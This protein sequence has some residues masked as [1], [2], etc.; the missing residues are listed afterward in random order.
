MKLHVSSKVVSL[1]LV[2]TLLLSVAPVVSATEVQPLTYTPLSNL[3]FALYPRYLPSSD[4]SSAS[5]TSLMTSGN[6]CWTSFP[7]GT[8][9]SNPVIRL[10]AYP[11]TSEE[12]LLASVYAFDLSRL[13]N[14]AITF[15]IKDTAS[16]DFVKRQ[17][18][19]AYADSQSLYETPIVVTGTSEWTKYSYDL[20]TCDL[21]QKFVPILLGMPF[22]ENRNIVSQPMIS[23]FMLES[24]AISPV[25]FEVSDNVYVKLA[26]ASPGVTI[27]YTTDGSLPTLSSDKYTE[28]LCL[29]N[30][31]TTTICAMA[32]DAN[33]QASALTSK[34]LEA[35]GDFYPTAD[36]AGG[37]VALGAEVTL[38]PPAGDKTPF[39]V[40]YTTNGTEPNLQSQVYSTPIPITGD[41]KIRAAASKGEFV[42]PSV[43]FQ[44]SLGGTPDGYEGVGGNDT[45]ISATDQTFPLELTDATLHAGSDVDYY[46]TTLDAE[47]TVH[48]TLGQ[49]QTG[50]IYA[51]ALLDSDGT[52]V[53][54]SCSLNVDQSITAKLPAGKYY[55]KVSSKDGAAFS[56]KSYTLKACAQATDSLNLS[57]MDLLTFSLAENSFY[58][59]CDFGINS[60]GNL[61]LATNYFTSWK[62]P[63]A[64]ADAP[65][66]ERFDSN[67]PLPKYDYHEPAQPCKYTASQSMYLPTA[68]DPQFRDRLKAAV[69]CYGA[70]DVS[71]YS[72]EAAT[73]GSSLQYCYDPV[74]ND[75]GNHSVTMIGWDDNVPRGN[76]SYTDENGAVQHP[77]YNGAY[78]VRNSWGADSASSGYFYISY[79]DASF[80]AVNNPAIYILDQ[81]PTDYNRQYTHNETG[82]S[83]SISSHILYT[84]NRFTCRSNES[85]K[86]V[87]LSI[88]SADTFYEISVSRKAKGGNTFS[89]PELKAV[90]KLSNAGYYTILLGS[91]FDLTKGDSFEVI[92]RLEGTPGTPASMLV[93]S[94]QSVASEDRSFP[95]ACA[96]A[97]FHKGESFILDPQ[98]NGDWID[99]VGSSASPFN[100]SI[101]AYTKDEGLGDSYDVAY[102]KNPSDVPATTV[103]QGAITPDSDYSIT[104]HGV[105]KTPSELPAG[106]GLSPVAIQASGAPS[107]SANTLPTQF[108]L[109]EIGVQSYVK[110][111]GILDSCWAFSATA[112]AELTYMRRNGGYE[113]PRTI[114]TEK[115][116]DAFS[117]TA[118]N[119]IY[120]AAAT[121]TRNDGGKLETGYDV[122]TWQFSGDLRSIDI[123]NTQS[124]SGKST[125]LFSARQPGTITLTAT[126]DGDL[127]RSASITVQLS[128]GAHNGPG[129]GGGGGSSVTPLSV[130]VANSVGG[131]GVATPSQVLPG[132]IVDVVLTP[133]LGYRVAGITIQDQSGNAVAFTKTTVNSFRFTM[134]KSKVTVTPL[135]E[136]EP[137]N[138]MGAFLDVHEG[139]W[140]Y[141]FVRYVCENELMN[142]TSATQFSPN[143]PMTRAMLS[144]ILWR[145][146]GE[147]EAEY[148]LRFS[149]YDGD[150]WYAQG[151]RW[152][153]SQDLLQG[154]ENGLLGPNDVI[155]REQLA[156]VLYRYA[157]FKGYNTT[158]PEET[159]I[160]NYDDFMHIS[161]WAYSAMNW[162][163][164][165]GLL[166]GSGNR[167]APQA[168]TTRAEVATILQRLREKLSS[169]SADSKTDA[170]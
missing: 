111:Q 100:L 75:A 144:T 101:R 43:T 16:S 93:E 135:F 138:I 3:V 64:E 58:R 32:V 66:P 145:M 76:F 82:V 130:S 37:T 127:S 49:P 151:V 146:E 65:Y 113:Y 118:D 107:L 13:P 68:A 21:K 62:G 123:L 60:G 57:E 150:A 5:H 136:K 161:E 28:P 42:G 156:A 92:V 167:L 88:A 19:L 38:L 129:G 70:V 79:E 29:P 41:T 119:N 53:L 84:K 104:G 131:S 170:T 120:N 149:D 25:T 40:R 15:Y 87:S 142:G 23:R 14:A 81:M 67:Q 47:R 160:L 39:S 80:C 18:A 137:P 73:S 125:P 112:S 26:C 17:V 54:R 99:T 9:D 141:G 97:V 20:S 94:K 155:T 44:Y 59:Y 162:A 86:A 46:V 27:Y 52:T 22:S 169:V 143:A 77:R 105:A 128:A 140:Y 72:S 36:P 114:T 78:L 2:L 124:R 7:A 45:P 1:L 121:L 24:M 166:Q 63:V 163:N 83:A 34:S 98:G 74:T 148:L 108:D 110:D 71:Y 117:Y 30:N 51:L 4:F 134:P 153:V 102:S 85:L 152:A 164:H 50:E 132:S 139:D 168:Y 116:T 33:G 35:S 106:T 69:Y 158:I 6:Y 126:I 109:R 154:Y 48:I 61:L 95:I 31:H 10:N 122:V 55:I 12:P 89:A 56:A 103:P 165:I 96:S 8:Q 147:P 90:G 157:V 91:D 11:T 133:N 115:S 159:E